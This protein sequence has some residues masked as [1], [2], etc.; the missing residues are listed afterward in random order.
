MGHLLQFQAFMWFLLVSVYVNR[1]RLGMPPGN[2][3]SDRQHYTDTQ[4]H[5]THTYTLTDRDVEKKVLSLSLGLWQMLWTVFTGL[6][7]EACMW[8]SVFPY[9]TKCKCLKGKVSVETGESVVW[10]LSDKLPPWP[11]KTLSLRL[12]SLNKM[13]SLVLALFRT[14]T[15]QKSVL[16]KVFLWYLRSDTK[17]LY[18]L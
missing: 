10:K 18:K 17:Q 6:C 4:G 12:S 9:P 16:G 1:C 15:S 2:I 5:S 14:T 13:T 3:K 11:L 8:Q 7:L